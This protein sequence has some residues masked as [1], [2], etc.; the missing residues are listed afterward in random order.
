MKRSKDKE[1][2][3]KMEWQKKIS[4]RLRKSEVIIFFGLKFE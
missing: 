3:M 4:K 2:E 1:N